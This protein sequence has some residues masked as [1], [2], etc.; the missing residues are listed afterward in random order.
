MG[1]DPRAIV[2]LLGHTPLPKNGRRP[3]T[4][5]CGRLSTLAGVPATNDPSA[6]Q[7]AESK[8]LQL[9]VAARV[10]LPVPPTVVSNDCDRL[11]AFLAAHPRSVIKTLRCDYVTSIPTRIID[12]RD[13]SD[14]TAVSLAPMIVQALVDCEADVRV[15]VVG[16]QVFAAAMRRP[17]RN[18]NPDW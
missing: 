16:D 17:D 9:T 4:A 2:G 15:C 6:E 3:K 12:E 1:R 7:R 13:L 8:I 5:P 11:R 14:P 18:E 10:G